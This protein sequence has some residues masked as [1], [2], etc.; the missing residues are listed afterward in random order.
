MARKTL[1]AKAAATVS[2]VV[3]AAAWERFPRGEDFGLEPLVLPAFKMPKFGNAAGVSASWNDAA[4]RIART[5]KNGVRV[6]F[7]GSTKEY[8]SVKE[9]FTA[10]RLPIQKHIKFRGVLKKSL[11][12]AFAAP[13][14]KVYMFEI[15]GERREE[16][17][18]AIKI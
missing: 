1:T 11:R 6:T 4:V 3:M 7:D 8:R 9:A 5:T 10:L 18:D 15:A 17:D 2:P 14:G 12:E 13:D 16:G